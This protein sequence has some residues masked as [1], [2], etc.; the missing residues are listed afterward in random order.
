MDKDWTYLP[1]IEDVL[2]YKNR[3]WRQPGRLGHPLFF[4]VRNMLHPC[5]LA[6]SYTHLLLET[7]SAIGTVGMSTGITR[8]LEPMS[9]ILIIFLMYCGRVGSMSFAL[10]FTQN[11]RVAPVRQPEEKITIG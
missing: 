1:E 6:V 11:K 2:K 3:E 9:R 10:S 5:S 4:A 7:F 8:A